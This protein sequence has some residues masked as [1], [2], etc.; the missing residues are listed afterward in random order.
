[1]AGMATT[2]E[3]KLNALAD[4]IDRA[5]DTGELDPSEILRLATEVHKETSTPIFVQQMKRKKGFVPA[6]KDANFRA[7]G[8]GT[9]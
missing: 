8:A 7:T 4:E 3:Q 6:P 1:M 2:V 9:A 5:F